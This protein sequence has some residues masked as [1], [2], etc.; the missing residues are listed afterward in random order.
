MRIQRLLLLIATALLIAGAAVHAAAFR[1]LVPVVNASGLPPFHANSYKAL[2]LAD[3]TTLFLLGIILAAI[4][5]QRQIAAFWLL[6]LVACIPLATAMLLY[7]FLG[8]F[9]AGHLLVVISALTVL[10]AIARRK[11]TPDNLDLAGDKI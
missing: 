1:K 10:G 8:T 9:F 6:L 5:M 3:S 11:R 4:S 2:W 7:A